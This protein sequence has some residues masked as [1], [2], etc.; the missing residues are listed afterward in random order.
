M[1]IDTINSYLAT[2]TVTPT[3][4]QELQDVVDA[5]NKVEDLATNEDASPLTVDEYQDLRFNFS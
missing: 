5:V 2:D 4:S 1:N 3:T